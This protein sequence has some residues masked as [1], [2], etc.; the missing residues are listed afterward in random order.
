MQR[1]EFISGP[2]DYRCDKKRGKCS[3]VR[4]RGKGPDSVVVR[5]GSIAAATAASK[6]SVIDL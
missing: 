2:F 5:S 3:V 6:N 4:G 1:V